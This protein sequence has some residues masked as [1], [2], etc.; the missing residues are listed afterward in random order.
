MKNFL[1]NVVIVVFFND[2]RRGSFSNKAC[3]FIADARPF[4]SSHIFLFTNYYHSGWFE[5][6]RGVF[7]LR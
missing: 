4:S 5:R 6:I 2:I 3:A 1:I 7:S